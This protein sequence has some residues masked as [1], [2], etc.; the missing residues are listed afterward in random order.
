MEKGRVTP[1]VLWTTSVSQCIPHLGMEKG[2]VTP[3]VLWLMSVSHTNRNLPHECHRIF[4]IYC[5]LVTTMSHQLYTPLY[6]PFGNG[7]GRGC[8]SAIP[9]MD[10][11]KFLCY[12]Y[13]KAIFVFHI[14]V[15]GGST[16][17][18]ELCS[19]LETLCLDRSWWFLPCHVMLCGPSL[20]GPTSNSLLQLYK[21]YICVP[22]WC[23]VVALIYWNFIGCKNPVPGPVMLVFTLSRH[24]TW[25]FPPWTHL[26]FS[27]T[28]IDRL[29]LCSTLI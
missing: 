12:D 10:P 25:P 15:G 8:S 27:V 6:T 22:H 26:N 17:L 9:S 7:E 11:L 14:G 16:D 28:I 2:G 24:A 1:S 18:L 29:Y 13:T 3:S 5:I 4:I 21:G 20:H 19:M 23:W